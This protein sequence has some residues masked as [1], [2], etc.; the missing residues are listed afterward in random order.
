MSELAVVVFEEGEDTEGLYG[1]LVSKIDAHR[2]RTH[3]SASCVS[4]V[5]S[6]KDAAASACASPAA[7]ILF[8]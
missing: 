1:M 3:A 8:P 4:S 7:P 6:W 2:D 5:A